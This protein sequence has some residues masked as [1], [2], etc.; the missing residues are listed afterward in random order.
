MT[1]PNENANIGPRMFSNLNTFYFSLW[2][3]GMYNSYNKNVSVNTRLPP[4][5]FISYKSNPN[6]QGINAGNET[7]TLDCYGLAIKIV[8]FKY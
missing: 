3:K 5:F 7:G 8:V 6:G 1:N 2:T 4:V